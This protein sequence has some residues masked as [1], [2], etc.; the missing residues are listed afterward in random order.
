MMAS[1]QASLRGQALHFGD[2][3]AGLMAN[4]NRLVY[5]TSTTNRYA[6]FFYAQYCPKTR[7]LVYVNAGH[8]PPYLLRKNGG[9]LDLILL[10][11]GGPVVGM[12]PPILVNYSQGEI[13]LQSGDMIVGFTDGISEA[14]NAL[15]DEWGEEAMLVELRS[16]A[17]AAPESILQHIVAEADKFADGAKQHDDMTM[18]VIKIAE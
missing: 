5:E 1:L 2:N 14:M 15:E 3:L 12:L 11:E 9:E 7:R 13:V 17:E 8:N 10:E 4:V 18:I 16:V 6:T